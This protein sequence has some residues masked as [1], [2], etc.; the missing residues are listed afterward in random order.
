MWKSDSHFTDF[1]CGE[2]K[3]EER[4]VMRKLSTG[5]IKKGFHDEYK[6]K[7]EISKGHF[8]KVY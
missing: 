7:Q 2:E 1:F 8:A 3:I 5:I 6:P 4:D